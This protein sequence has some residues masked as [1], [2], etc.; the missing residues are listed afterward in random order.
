ME[1][2]AEFET[3]NPGLFFCSNF[4]R[5]ISM[6]DCVKNAFQ[7]ADAVAAFLKSKV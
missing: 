3:R 6:S 2:C 1:D 7:T 5:G 4:Y